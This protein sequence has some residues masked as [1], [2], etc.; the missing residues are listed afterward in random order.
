MEGYTKRYMEGNTEGHMEG[1]MERHMKV[2]GGYMERYM[3]GYMEG[4][5][6]GILVDH[7]TDVVDGVRVD[8]S[9]GDGIVTGLGEGHVSDVTE[10]V[11]KVC[12]DGWNG[13][14]D[15]VCQTI[16]LGTKG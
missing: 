4:T 3:E 1:Y 9:M 13:A 8:V 12:K 14:G 11:E 15:G 2:Y 16:G 7:V 10:C 5:C 6:R